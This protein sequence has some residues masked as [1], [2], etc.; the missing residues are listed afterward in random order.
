MNVGRATNGSPVFQGKMIELPDIYN[1]RIN[2]RRRHGDD[3]WPM[4]AV[5]ATAKRIFLTREGH[6]RRM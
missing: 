2:S 4:A 5:P 3:T 6:K 1:L